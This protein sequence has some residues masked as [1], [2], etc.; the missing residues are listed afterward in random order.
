MSKKRR[1]FTDTFKQDVVKKIQQGR[2]LSQLYREL[3]LSPSTVNGWIKKAR[4]SQTSQNGALTQNERDDL[5]HLRKWVR[6]D[7]ISCDVSMFACELKC[8][9]SLDYRHG[10]IQAR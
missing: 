6:E 5:N 3:K 10:R 4:E 7:E 1:I 2:S 9:L 8:F